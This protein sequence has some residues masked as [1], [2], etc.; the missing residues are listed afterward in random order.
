MPPERPLENAPDA[1]DPVDIESMESTQWN[2]L[3]SQS[4]LAF[5]FVLCFLIGA[6]VYD[7][8]I[9]A[10]NAP[11]LDEPIWPFDPWH[12]TQVDWMLG[13]SLSAFGF[14]GVLPAIR[15]RD[16]TW[17][18]FRRLRRDKAAFF[19]GIFLSVLALVGLVGPLLVQP[20]VHIEASYQPPIFAII[21]IGAVANCLGDVSNGKC[22]GTMQYPLG[23]TFEGRGVFLYTALA[24]RTALVLGFVIT[25]VIVPVAVTVGTVSAYAG[26]WVDTLLMRSVEIV[27][28]LPPIFVYII[29]RFLLGGGGDMFL[30]IAVFGLLSWGNV[31]RLVRNDALA[32]REEL[33]VTVAES[34]GGSRWYVI[35][36]HLL[37]NLTPTVITATT[38]QIPNLILAEAA[39]SFLNFGVP[40][41]R[42]WGTL[43]ADG[44]LG[45]RW[46]TLTDVWWIS[47][48]PVI[49]LTLTVVTLSV[50]G[51]SLDEILDPRAN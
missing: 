3:P 2:L 4:V 7:H 16:L 21:D 32:Q 50:L 11:L 13:F 45:T 49:V 1:M 18:Y 19:S 29:V 47:L 39:L 42:S 8:S 30:L 31:A 37:P 12:P 40:G 6:F 25:V 10:A 33:F 5:F 36:H 9:L 15:H 17:T 28:I 34:A 44:T 35:R 51:D 20:Q 14:F 23:T 48:V 26:G 27:Q 22:H 24:A 41:V 43:I 46:G 38:L